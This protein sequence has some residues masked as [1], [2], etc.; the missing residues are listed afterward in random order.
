MSTPLTKMHHCNL[1]LVRCMDFRQTHDGAMRD[2]VAHL[3]PGQYCDTIALAGVVQMLAEPENAPPIITSIGI[4]I[5]SHKAKTVVLIDHTNCG[6]RLLRRKQKGCAPF[7]SIQEEQDAIIS[8]LRRAR[9]VVL[10]QYPE[11]NVCLYLAVLSDIDDTI[12]FRL[13]PDN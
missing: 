11:V 12:D 5:E 10:D 1:V 4:G 13:I 2:F 7:D 6:Y 9:Q 3:F 8:D